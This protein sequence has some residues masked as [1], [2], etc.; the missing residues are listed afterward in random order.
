MP[1]DIWIP[2]GPEWPGHQRRMNFVIMRDDC[3]GSPIIKL[4]YLVTVNFAGS[5]MLI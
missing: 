5:E 2:D 3:I 1:R 4:K